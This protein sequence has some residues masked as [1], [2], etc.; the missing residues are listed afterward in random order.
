MTSTLTRRLFAAGLALL[1]APAL[2]QARQ[3]AA[4]APLSAADQAMVDR[5]VAYL[6]GL[7]RAKGRFTQTDARGKVARGDLYLQRPG[8]ARLVYDA[9][10][11]LLVISDGNQVAVHDKRLNSF[12]LY[13][14]RASPLSLFL[15][16]EIRLD[17]G[18]IVSNVQRGQGTFSLT[19]RD[20]KRETDGQITLVF[21]ETPIALR[22]WIIVDAQGARTRVA[23]NSLAPTGA[24]DRALFVIRDPR[25]K[26]G[27]RP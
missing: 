17:R 10:N 26:G 27:G 25:P 6:Q 19:A 13:P 8:K 16:K 7:T 15:A 22:E 2:A 5:A 1:P 20:R 14:L 23:I 3:T 9:P 12:E 18:V 4:P 11:N 24:F 21:N